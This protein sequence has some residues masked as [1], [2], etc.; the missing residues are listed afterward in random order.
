MR[1]SEYSSGTVLLLERVLQIRV[2]L[3]GGRGSREGE[4]TGEGKV[5]LAAQFGEA[6]LASPTGFT[7]FGCQGWLIGEM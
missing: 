6:V 2:G 4:I 1:T 7:M 5:V 3:G